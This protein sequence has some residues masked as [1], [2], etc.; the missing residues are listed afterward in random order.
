MGH[1]WS[2]NRFLCYCW[3]VTRGYR[4]RRSRPSC[5][6]F[7]V[8]SRSIRSSIRRSPSF[9]PRSISLIKDM[10]FK[11][12]LIQTQMSKQSPN[13][14]KLKALHHQK[15]NK[16]F[17]AVVVVENETDDLDV[18]LI[19]QS[20]INYCVDPGALLQ[21]AE[22][23]CRKTRVVASKCKVFVGNI[24]YRLKSRELKEFFGCF[25]KVICAQIITD[26]IKKRSRG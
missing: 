10:C 25:G 22:E 5:F 20:D 6:R 26:R 12:T 14:Q 2:I 19:P 7:L 8:P 24:S 3:P 1:I 16:G 23:F 11:W 21:K 9:H 13:L 4:V 17:L 18:S 15:R